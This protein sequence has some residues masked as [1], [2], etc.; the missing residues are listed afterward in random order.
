MNNPNPALVPAPKQYSSAR[1]AGKEHIPLYPTGFAAFRI[2]QLSLAVL[3]LALSAYGALCWKGD[4]VGYSTDTTKAS[5]VPGATIPTT[6][7]SR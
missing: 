7:A 4:H 2:A 3:V 1:P 5:T 6:R